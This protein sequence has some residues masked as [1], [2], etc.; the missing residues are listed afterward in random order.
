MQI[1]NKSVLTNVTKGENIE[2]NVYWPKYPDTI[3]SFSL[4]QIPFLALCQLLWVKTCCVSVYGF[5]LQRN[6]QRPT[7]YNCN[8]TFLISYSSNP[9]SWNTDIVWLT[10]IF[11]AIFQDLFQWWST[12]FFSTRRTFSCWEETTSVPLSTAS[13]VSMMN[14]SVQNLCSPRWS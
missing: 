2:I 11:Y 3:D 1:T 13:M 6:D 9:L 4:F 12:F 8:V 5:C 7:I 14:V 10:K